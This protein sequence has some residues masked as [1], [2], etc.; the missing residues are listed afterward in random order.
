MYFDAAKSFSCRPDTL[1]FFSYWQNN[2]LKAR[3]VT[4][5]QTQQITVDVNSIRLVGKWINHNPVT[6]LETGT[7]SMTAR[8][9]LDLQ[10]GEGHIMKYMCFI[11]WYKCIRVCVCSETV[12]MFVW[13]NE[14]CLLMD[15]GV[16]VTVTVSPR[17]FFI[18]C[19]I[20]CPL[21]P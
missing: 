9:N 19:V 14:L 20:Q 2:N 12:W 11:I 13:L 8:G 10:G 17:L 6:I 15:Q 4:E 16:K 5:A 18:F 21:F 7:L 3:V 1:S